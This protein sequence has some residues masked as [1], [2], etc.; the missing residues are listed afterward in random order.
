MTNQEV[1]AKFRL[2]VEPKYGHDRATQIL[3]RCWELE[4]L[5]SVTEL[6]GLFD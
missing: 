3:A 4:T 5:T 2:A 1:E 6:I